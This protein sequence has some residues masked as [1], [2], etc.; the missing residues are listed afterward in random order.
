MTELRRLQLLRAAYLQALT[1]GLWFAPT[2]LARLIPPTAAA[3][4]SERILGAP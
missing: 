1:T 3:M 2:A 4:R